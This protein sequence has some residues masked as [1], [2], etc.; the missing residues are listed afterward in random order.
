MILWIRR[1]SLNHKDL[2]SNPR[3]PR[4]KPDEVEHTFASLALVCGEIPGAA[5]QPHSRVY[6]RICPKGGRQRVTE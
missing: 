5:Y 3:H 1:L 2:S 6:E 4:Q